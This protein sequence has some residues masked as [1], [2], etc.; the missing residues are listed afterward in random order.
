MKKTDPYIV[1]AILKY[2]DA[3]LSLQRIADMMNCAKTTVH[4]ILKRGEKQG[5]DYAKAQ[6]LGVLS[7]ANVLYPPK[8]LTPSDEAIVEKYRKLCEDPKMNRMKL[9][10]EYI[11]DYPDGIQYSQFCM[12]IKKLA[13]ADESRRGYV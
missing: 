12:R 1:S 9:W 2:H 7:T 11:L 3:G 5:I 10:K 6:E 4:D 13:K 8:P